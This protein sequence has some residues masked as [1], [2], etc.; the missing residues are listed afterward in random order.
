MKLNDVIKDCIALKLDGRATDGAIQVF[1]GNFLSEQKPVLPIEVRDRETLLWMMQGADDVH[2]YVASGVAH[3]NAL[4]KPVDRFPAVRIY[5]LK[6]ERLLDIGNLGVFFERN[7]LPLKPINDAGFSTLIEDRDYPQRFGTWR[8]ERDSETR[9]FEGL[10]N[11]RRKNTAVD[12]AIWLSSNGKCLVCG[13]E[14]DRVSTTTVQGGSG[15]LIGL[16]LCSIHEA[17][18]QEQS[19]LLNYVAKHLGGMAIFDNF[20]PVSASEALELACEALQ[21][22]LDCTVDKVQDQT[23]T[24]R[25]PSGVVVIVRYASPMNYAYNVQAPG[26]ANLSR[27]DSANHHKVPYGPDHLHPDLR[28][29][30]KKIVESSFTYGNVGMDVKLIRKMILDAETKLM[31]SSE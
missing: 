24:A 1:G 17:E 4:Y 16:Q 15:L 12:G 27:V 6:A 11:G 23:I 20:Q 21:T 30:K 28:K 29:S 8:Q 2:I 25:R 31:V 9:S 10:F 7:G 19:T 22:E 14:T 26:G 18:A 3:F 5:Y 13:A